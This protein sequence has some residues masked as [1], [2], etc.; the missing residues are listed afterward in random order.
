[1]A[2]QMPIE[3]MNK[4]QLK[5]YATWYASV[6]PARIKILTAEIQS[7][8][9]YEKWKADFSPTSLDGL[10]LWFY[11][12]IKNLPL[13]NKSIEEIQNGLENWFFNNVIP[14]IHHITPE[15]IFA[16]FKSWWIHEL[17]SN[18]ESTRAADLA[19]QW[20]YERI[21]PKDPK[22]HSEDLLAFENQWLTI[23]HDQM[24]DPICFSI[25]AD[26]G[27]YLSQ[28][29]AYY[30]K[31]NYPHI[32]WHRSFGSLKYRHY[33]SHVHVLETNELMVDFNP[34]SAMTDIGFGICEGSKNATALIDLF[35]LWTSNSR[36][37]L[38]SCN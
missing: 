12:R 10:G 5:D 13:R 21:A 30:L 2:F 20:F 38:F 11:G 29:F 8:P 4:E 31:E 26:I 19:M 27:M 6:L 7:T 24:I 37:P 18:L 1:M 3:Q 33:H 22:E 32:K 35:N 16:D 15:A 25:F 14:E 23:T 9:N 34:I 36:W 17:G 28:V